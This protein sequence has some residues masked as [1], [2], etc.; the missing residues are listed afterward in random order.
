ML[1]LNED[2]NYLSGGR[3]VEELPHWWPRR[4]GLKGI[5]PPPLPPQHLEHFSPKDAC[6]DLQY[7]VYTFWGGRWGEGNTFRGGI[8]AYE[9]QKRNI[10]NIWNKSIKDMIFIPSWG[11]GGHKYFMMIDEFPWWRRRPRRR[12]PRTP[13]SRPRSFRWTGSGRTRSSCD[14]KQ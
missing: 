10:G 5:I 4:L 11:G 6:L 9:G 8:A 7:S 12:A 3:L 2:S 1:V 13:A 14:S